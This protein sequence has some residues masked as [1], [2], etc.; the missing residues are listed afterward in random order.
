METKEEILRECRK[1]SVGGT[2]N[3]DGVEGEEIT[4]EIMDPRIS[5]PMVAH[6]RDIFSDPACREPVLPLRA[7]RT[8]VVPSDL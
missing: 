1:L 3:I 8:L 2:T 5:D 4:L 6:L 7:K